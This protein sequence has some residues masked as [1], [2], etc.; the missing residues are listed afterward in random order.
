MDGLE[1]QNE[2]QNRRCLIEVTEM[3][4]RNTQ[5]RKDRA[6][7]EGIKI[8]VEKH[9]GGY[10][11]YPLGMNGVVVRHGDTRR[12]TVADVKSAVSSHPE[13]FRK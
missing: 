8:A 6:T 7:D 4:R 1:V 2:I 10:V 5:R 3:A 12:Q 9:T 11:A 13:V